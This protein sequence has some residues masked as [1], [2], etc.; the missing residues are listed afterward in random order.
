MP[1]R[2][3]LAALLLGGMLAPAASAAAPGVRGALGG[4]G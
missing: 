3:M 4:R 2:F 1:T